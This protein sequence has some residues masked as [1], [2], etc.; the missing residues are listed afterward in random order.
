MNCGSDFVPVIGTINCGNYEELVR[1][2]Q[3][4]GG[5][6]LADAFY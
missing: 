5:G 3:A 1:A 4:T 6:P 2:F